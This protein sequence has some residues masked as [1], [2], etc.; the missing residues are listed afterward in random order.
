M[1]ISATPHLVLLL[2]LNTHLFQSPV[3]VQANDETGNR[4]VVSLTPETE[5][6]GNQKVFWLGLHMEILEGWHV[7]WRNPGDSGLPTTIHW[8]DHP[9]LEPG[10]IHWP[11]PKI[12]D[13]EGIST[14]GYSG[15]VD[16]LIP[17]RVKHEKLD[18]KP[19][20]TELLKAEVRWLVCKDICIPESAVVS[21]EIGPDRSFPAYSPEGKQRLDHAKATIPE[22][23]PYWQARARIDND[24]FV[25]ALFALSE[26]AIRPDADHVYFFPND[27]GRIEHSLP[28]TNRWEGDTLFV[29]TPVSRYLS[30]PP[31]QLSGVFYSPQGWFSNQETHAIELTFPLNP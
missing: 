2:L 23:T 7:Y 4:V 19:D 17:V 12:F 5:R 16:L 21:L 18:K 1:K 28:Q 29:R 24:A 25:I 6:F 11:Y 14:Y 26:D 9:L 13:E 22:Q 20:K 15:E 10:V 30:T 3:Q 8:H 31:D 27:P